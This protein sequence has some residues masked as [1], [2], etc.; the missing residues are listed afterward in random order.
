MPGPEPA[1]VWLDLAREY[2]ERWHHQQHIRDAV[3]RPGLKQ[4]HYLRPALDAFVRALPYTF[5]ETWADPG[6]SVTLT[7][8]GPG[9]GQWS[10]RKEAIGWQ[11]YTGAPEQSTAEV[12]LTGDDAWR[13]FTKGLE[14]FEVQGR[15]EIIGDARLG[16]QIFEMVSIIA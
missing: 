14:P 8:T 10:I 16:K 9:G 12:I 1:P 4:A 6:S 5:R 7:L 2:T 11:L 13:L 3:G 15:A